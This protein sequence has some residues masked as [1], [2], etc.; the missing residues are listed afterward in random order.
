[1]T[2]FAPY[3]SL[4]VPSHKNCLGLHRLEFASAHVAMPRCGL[5]PHSFQLSPVPEGHR[6]SVSISLVLGITRVEFLH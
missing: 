2:I 3:L 4:V 1:M 6:L 5:L